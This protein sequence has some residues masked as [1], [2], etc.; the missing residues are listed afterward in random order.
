MSE[1]NDKK[2]LLS[3]IYK[4]IFKEIYPVDVGNAAHAAKINNY[5]KQRKEKGYQYDEYH[6]L[7]LHI[8]DAIDLSGFDFEINE[9]NF[10][11]WMN[12][13]SSPKY[14]VTINSILEYLID[15]CNDKGKYDLLKS[16]ILTILKS[17][18]FNAYIGDLIRD[19][20]KLW[21]LKIENDDRE[22]L[23]RTTKELL[24]LL[25]NKDKFAPYLLK[26]SHELKEALHLENKEKPVEVITGNDEVNI[27]EVVVDAE[28]ESPNTY[29]LPQVEKR[30]PNKYNK[31][32]FI[33]VAAALLILLPLT[34]IINNS[35]HQPNKLDKS[36]KTVSVLSASNITKSPDLLSSNN[37]NVSKKDV[38]ENNNETTSQESLLSASVNNVGTSAAVEIT[39]A[40]QDEVLSTTMNNA[41][42]NTSAEATIPPKKENVSSV[43][44]KTLSN[45][46]TT[47]VEIT[48]SP[49]KKEPILFFW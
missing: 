46:S 44:S 24:Y 31:Y 49:Q 4:T 13:I 41:V 27:D 9:G 40:P 10:H 12:G 37:D 3:L 36:N 42:S 16:R 14:L 45:L 8:D 11:N 21:I 22:T 5:S 19:T 29:N 15:T 18:E 35:N 7:K 39:P 25:K 23:L 26:E 32:K 34:Y 2:Y 1:K 43:S 38:G 6:Y 47:A 28:I 17:N 33:A 30:I 48:S 20:V